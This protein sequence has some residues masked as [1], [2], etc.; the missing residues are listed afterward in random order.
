MV[1]VVLGALLPGQASAD[2]PA[3][4]AARRTGSVRLAGQV[5]LSVLHAGAAERLA[6]HPA[7]APLTLSFSLPLRDPAALD[8]LIARQAE[9]HTQISRADLYA[10]FAPP[11][12]QVDALTSWLRTE[13]YTVTHTNA[14]RTAVTAR[15]ATGTVERSLAT[16]LDD[17]RRD[18]YANGKVQVAAY[19]FFSNTTA[20]QL[21]ARLGVTAVSGLTDVD[22]FFTHAELTGEGT[23]GADVAG[24]T[25]TRSGG[26]YYPRDLR[27]LYGIA[28]GAD[29]ASGQTIG[30]V[31]W[32]AGETQAAMTQYASTTGDTPI[33]VDPACVAT[34][35]P[36]SCTTTAVQGDHLLSILENGNTN[37]AAGTYEYAGNVET[38]LDIESAHATGTGAGMKYYLSNCTSAPPA[39][40]GLSNATCNGTDVGMELAISDAAND[41]TLHTVSNSWGYGGEVEWGLADP[42]RTATQSS[43]ALAAAAGTTFWFSTGDAGTYQSGYPADSA[44]V[45]AVGGTSLFSTATLAASSPD[46][47]VRST[48]TTWTG[49][50]SWCSNLE[51]RP[52]WQN[53]AG[54]AAKASCPG[55]AIPDVSAVADPNTGFYYVSSRNSTGSLASGGVGGTSL[56]APVMAGMAVRA[57]AYLARQS[58]AGPAPAAGF[59][60]PVLYQLGNS[61]QARYF[62]D[63]GCGNTANPTG[64]PDGDAAALGWDQAT[65]WGEIDW[66]HYATGYAIALGATGLSQPGSLAEPSSFRCAKTPTNAALRGVALPTSS[67]GYAVG[68]PSGTTPWPAKFLAA[69]SWGAS[70]GFLKSVDGGAS[71]QSTN[72]DALGI[73]CPDAGTCVEVTDGGRIRRTTD[74]G[75]TWAFVSS[76]FDKALTSVTCPSATRCYAAGDRGT[77]LTSSDAGASWAVA[78]TADG[79]AL[80]WLACPGTTVCYAVDNYAHVQKTTDGAATWTLMSTPVTTPGLEVPGS[81]GPNPY[82]GLFGITCTGVDTCV[83]VGGYPSA[84]N[85]DPPIVTTTDGGATWTRRT[86][87]AGTGR[88]LNGVACVST[89]CYAVGRSGA[90]VTSADAGVTWSPMT[91][92]TTSQLTG[93]TCTTQADCVATGQGGVV[94]V[95]RG[96]TWSATTAQAGGNFLAAVTC[97]TT[98]SCVA[99]GKHGATIAFDPG[100]VAGT[101]VLQA[102][103]G[104]TAVM[105]ALSCAGASTCVAVGASGVILQTT[106]GGQTWRPRSSGTAAALAGVSC[107]ASSCVAVG[108]VVAGAAVIVASGDGG[109]TWAPRTSG[110]ASALSAVSC[111]STSV[112]VAVGTGGVLIRSADG[113]SL[114]APQN[115]GTTSLNGV[116]C[117]SA[118]RCV[119]VGAI[120]A[121]GGTATAIASTDGGI[122]WAVQSSA[123]PQP[124]AAVACVDT[125]ACI[126][127]GALGTTVATTDGGATWAQTGN[128]L[129]GP[130]SALNTGPALTTTYAAACS[131]AACVV[132]TASAGD[133]MR[134]GIVSVAVHRTGPAGQA[135]AL[136]GL[137]PTDAGITVS[138]ASDLTGTLSCTTTATATSAPGTYP[139]TGCTGLSG[140]GVTVTYDPA[141]DYT[142]TRASQTITFGALPDKTFGDPPFDVSATASSGLPVS[143]AAAGQ[144]TLSGATVTLTGAGTCTITASQAGDAQVA[145][146][147]DV[148]R[149]F[150][151]AKAAQTI[152]F[153][154]LPD[155]AASD[156][157]FDLTATASS[158]LPVGFAATGPCTVSGATVTLTRGLGTCTITASQPG[159][160]DY[161]AAGDVVRSFQVSAGGPTGVT[162]RGGRVLLGHNG[163]LLRWS[164]GRDPRTLGYDVLRVRRGHVAR[165][166]VT[167]R[168]ILGGAARTA[169]SYAFRDTKGRRGDRY[170]VVERHLDG[171][172][173]THALGTARTPR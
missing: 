107:V 100:N 127:D 21:P 8:A 33:T 144:C 10:R 143:F 3:W 39:D 153:G 136:T 92:G 51:A 170:Y 160:G 157:P 154:P 1:A 140:D 55:R 23:D 58:Y 145:A 109:A 156:P 15:A 98:T 131:T 137:S 132:G 74:G 64:G 42:F 69:G 61:A 167:R 155:K 41:R 22:R 14:D 59:Q 11:Q 104:T 112:C 43:F 56:A 93:I 77:V 2:Q 84:A 29:D 141:G 163:V 46:A 18:A 97:R 4:A 32:G 7:D 118:S 146:A 96:T 57:Q 113:G 151:V 62:H 116:T 114:W 19:R 117:P 130:V 119:A 135:P 168:L 158:G 122:S 85:V 89:T 150:T 106:D 124:L 73:A 6:D 60:A 27:S 25:L 49:G 79:S 17:F 35:S 70:N 67:V 86:S 111:A 164:S 133:L 30:F 173:V 121:G 24:G 161:A 166:R 16:T 68:S 78:G 26:G 88:F 31:L 80:Y 28:P 101:A 13:G 142:V 99:A 9:T 103:G 34:G 76:P 125:L 5:P 148:A 162:W 48:A 91:S 72:P 105:A 152:A 138:P 53:G 102:G 40:S 45:A 115:V 75:T 44:Y 95:L 134:T 36:S 50:G 54:V 65:G 82:S 123:S 129:S 126:A 171:S 128:P 63:V 110:T 20:P 71:W 47:A 38:A 169:R 90:I 159:N 120:P 139:V 66:A 147:P 87:N 94:D 81:G 52:A 12:A 172:H 83:A 108:A 165:V 149:S 37:G